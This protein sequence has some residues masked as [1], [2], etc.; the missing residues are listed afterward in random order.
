MRLGVRDHDEIHKT[1]NISQS[2]MRE[3]RMRCNAILVPNDKLFE[4]KKDIWQEYFSGASIEVPKQ[5][6]SLLKQ[7]NR[8]LRMLWSSERL[9]HNWDF[10]ELIEWLTEAQ[11]AYVRMII[12]RDFFDYR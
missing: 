4:M 7:T 12:N 11:K 1:Q 10:D 8:Y 9:R 6:W 2:K 3:F 5:K